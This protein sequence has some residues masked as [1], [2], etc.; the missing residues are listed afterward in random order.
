MCNARETNHAPE[1]GCANC[2]ETRNLRT[3]NGLTLCPEC[4]VDSETQAQEAVLVGA[5][6][7]GR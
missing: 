7:N 3:V 1:S 4:I 5:D 6:P 2:G